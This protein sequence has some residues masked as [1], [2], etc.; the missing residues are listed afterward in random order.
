[1]AIAR[2]APNASRHATI[3]ANARVLKMPAMAAPPCA[4]VFTPGRTRD[5]PGSDHDRAGY[6]GPVASAASENWLDILDALLAGEP[7]ALARITSLV[8][9]FLARYRAYDHRDSWD[10]LCQEVLISL[11]KSARKGRINDSRT[12]VS[13]V[14]TITRNEFYDWLRKNKRGEVELEEAPDGGHELGELELDVRRALGRLPERERR[15]LE[16]VYLLG[17]TYDE[18]AESTGT[19][20]GSLKRYLRQGV[21]ALRGEL[22]SGPPG[23]DPN[24]AHPGSLPPGGDLEPPGRRSTVEA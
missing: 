22:G 19:P 17:Q 8:T 23:G 21:A 10:D 13:Y 12:F 14:G 15:A 3:L 18:A 1:M 9:G 6:H 5:G 20:L 16:C 2:T 11:I 7:A 24:S 4:F